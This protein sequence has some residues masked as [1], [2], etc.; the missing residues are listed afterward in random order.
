MMICLLVHI[1]IDR[2]YIH[3]FIALLEATFIAKD[4]FRYWVSIGD[5]I[6]SIYYYLMKTTNFGNP[7]EGN[8]QG[9]AP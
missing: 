3:D 8:L 7:W 9:G 5:S 2:A 1:S 6:Y 4:L